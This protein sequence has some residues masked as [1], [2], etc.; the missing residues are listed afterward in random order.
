VLKIFFVLSY[1][2]YIQ[3]W[4]NIV[5]DDLEQHHLIEKKEKMPLNTLKLYAIGI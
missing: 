3:I 5:M 4:L 1:F 2:E